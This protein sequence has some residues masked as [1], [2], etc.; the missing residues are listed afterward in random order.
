[1]SRRRSLLTAT[2]VAV[3]LLAAG[4]ALAAARDGPPAGAPAGAGGLP[5][6]VTV[7]PQGER[8][9]LPAFAGEQ[10]AAGRARVELRG[11]TV[12][13][14]WASWCGPCRA[15]ALAL[16][17]AHRRLAPGGARFV[18]VNVRD[19][20]AAAR[21]YLAEFEITYPSLYDR[22]ARF[23]QLLGPDA[24][25]APPSTLVVDGAGRVAARILGVLP[26]G[27]PDAQAAALERVIAAVAGT[28]A[29]P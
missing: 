22:P 2:L 12:V 11:A 8:R 7:V 5:A 4:V 13:N 19:D 27:A 17:R 14:F 15:E 6:N 26:G 1:M 23:A 20:R 24:P 16:E 29:A 9:P 25:P 3:V 10:V 28:A 18:G 21:A